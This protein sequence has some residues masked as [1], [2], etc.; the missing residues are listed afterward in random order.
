MEFELRVPEE[1]EYLYYGDDNVADADKEFYYYKYMRTDNTGKDIF[2]RLSPGWIPYVDPRNPSKTFYNNSAIG[3]STWDAPIYEDPN[4]V[5]AMK[6]LVET[7]PQTVILSVNLHGGLEITDKGE[8]PSFTLPED[9]KVCT[10]DNAPPGACSIWSEK[11]DTYLEAVIQMSAVFNREFESRAFEGVCQ[12]LGDLF[13]QHEGIDIR[14]AEMKAKDIDSSYK[15]KIE[16][17][18]HH[19]DKIYETYCYAGGSKIHDKGFQFQL[20]DVGKEGVYR[21]KINILNLGYFPTLKERVPNLINEEFFHGLKRD[22]QTGRDGVTVHAVNFELKDILGYL[23]ARGVRNIL[24]I[25][26]SC[27]SFSSTSPREIRRLARNTRTEKSKLSIVKSSS[28][29]LTKRG[30]TKRGG[31]KRKGGKT[32][33]GWNRRNICKKTR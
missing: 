25:D 6:K 2:L 23:Y 11:V 1:W 18:L 16:Y 29:S 5:A 10:I 15:E 14:P 8:P 30:G 22:P 33:R 31:T 13:R 17:A 9:L 27:S 28:R 21:S 20:A 24:L 4:D 26:F 12:D 3:K 19:E 32:K 7:L